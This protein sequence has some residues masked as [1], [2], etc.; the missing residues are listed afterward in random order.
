MRE[1]II[2]HILACL[3]GLAIV[4]TAPA[5]ACTVPKPYDPNRGLEWHSREEIV[6]IA[7]VIVE[8]VVQPY[9]PRG[10]TVP[11][12]RFVGLA[13]MRIDKVW[14]GHLGPSV[15]LLF[16]WGSGD[17]SIPPPFGERVRF[18]AH[19]VDKDRVLNDAR[20][21]AAE[22]PEFGPFPD[23]LVPFLEVNKDVL[24][25]PNYIE[26]MDLPLSDAEFD[27]LLDAYQAKTD[28][29][30]REAANGGDARLAYATHLEENRETHRA[31]EVYED[32]LQ[33]HPDD[34]D[35]LL[36]LAL[37]R[38]EVRRNGEPEATLAEVV[39]RA[40]KTE[41]WRGKIL[42]TRFMATGKLTPEWKDWT[43]LKPTQS[44]YCENR[45]MNFDDAS[46][47]RSD[48]AGCDFQEATFRRGSFLGT[49]L[50]HALFG[51]GPG[52]R[53]DMTGAKYD[54]VTKFPPDFDPTKE[55]MINVEGICQAP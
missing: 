15:A 45:D 40:P 8:G 38:T 23:E 34:L 6:R 12:N 16:Q 10:K 32:V 46:F 9:A 3:V 29:M 7:E 22:A 55:G 35:L 39:Q 17:C 53:V 31:L 52:P 54:C 24:S 43:E 37:V 42:R 51:Y 2:T 5:A 28:A 20:A 19:I 25:Y 48:L 21:L 50:S 13:T 30:K 49:D 36:T 41:E 44:P 11:R 4:G 27:R 33:E 1:A 14:K 47:D 26:G 18:G